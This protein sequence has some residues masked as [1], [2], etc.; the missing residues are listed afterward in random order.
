MRPENDNS[1]GALLFVVLT[2]TMWAVVV[3]AQLVRA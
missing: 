2:L 3:L 1:D